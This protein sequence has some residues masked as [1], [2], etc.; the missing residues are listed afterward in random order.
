[1]SKDIYIEIKDRNTFLQ[2]LK[3]NTGVMLFKFKASWCKPC[4][5]IQDDVD[6]YFEKT[7]DNVTCFDIDIDEYSDV[8]KFLKSR[9]MVNGV[10]SI[11]GYIKNN[12]TFVPDFSFSGTDKRQLNDFFDK[13][14]LLSN[15]HL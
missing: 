10:P 3:E 8:Y 15:T 11:L 6:K 14:N 13:I 7:N 1:M 4:K 9:K 12:D 2:Y 5:I